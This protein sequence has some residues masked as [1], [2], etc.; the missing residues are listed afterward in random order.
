MAE[1]HESYLKFKCAE[2][3]KEVEILDTEE[4]FNLVDTQIVGEARKFYCWDCI[5]S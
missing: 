5:E 1:E 3:E 4:I 2:C